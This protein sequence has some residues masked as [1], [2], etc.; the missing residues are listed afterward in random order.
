VKNIEKSSKNGW[1]DCLEVWA[2]AAGQHFSLGR[3]SGHQW[4]GLR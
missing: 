2:A 4:I 3:F 1:V